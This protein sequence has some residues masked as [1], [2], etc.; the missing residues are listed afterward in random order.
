MN[1]LQIAGQGKA[2]L[3][4]MRNKKQT[5]QDVHKSITREEEKSNMKTNADEH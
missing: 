2:H 5:T 1:H 4:N 3:S